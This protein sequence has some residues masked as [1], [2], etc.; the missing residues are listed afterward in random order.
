MEPLEGLARF[1]KASAIIPGGLRARLERY[2]S[3]AAY[4]GRAAKPLH[5]APRLPPSRTRL[6]GFSSLIVIVDLTGTT[7][8]PKPSRSEAAGLDQRR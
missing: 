3:A 1:W 4:S 7:P 6:L 8:F 2:G 5:R